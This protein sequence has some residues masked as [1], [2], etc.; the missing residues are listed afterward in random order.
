MRP[1]AQLISTVKKDII[2]AKSN[3]FELVLKNKGVN[4]SALKV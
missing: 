3:G 4:L 1:F 2:T